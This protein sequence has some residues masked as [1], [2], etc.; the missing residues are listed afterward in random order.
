M[1]SHF[2]HRHFLL[3]HCALQLVYL[4]CF[5]FGHVGR[6]CHLA[7]ALRKAHFRQRLNYL[8]TLV[9]VLRHRQ[10]ACLCQRECLSP[11]DGLIGL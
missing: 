3:N 8:L 9:P 7:D 6:Y 5:C 4:A 11:T 2:V 10:D 1:P